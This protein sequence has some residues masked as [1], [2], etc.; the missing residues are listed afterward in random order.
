MFYVS[1]WAWDLIICLLNVLTSDFVEVDEAIFHGV[2]KPCELI[3]YI[4]GIQKSDLDEVP[5]KMF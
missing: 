3:F 1:E 2:E 4:L 5:E